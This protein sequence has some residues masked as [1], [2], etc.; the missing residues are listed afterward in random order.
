MFGTANALSRQMTNKSILGR[1]VD[2]LW[3]SKAQKTNLNWQKKF[4]QTDLCIGMGSCQNMWKHFQRKTRLI[5]G[6][7][8]LKVSSPL[9]F[10]TSRRSYQR[11]CFPLICRCGIY[12]RNN[13]KRLYQNILKI[14]VH[15]RRLLWTTS[16]IPVF[17]RLIFV[18]LVWNFYFAV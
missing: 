17:F 5:S 7:T 11:I 3:H 2:P 9:C 4:H 15:H 18:L 12:C 10:N 6:L 14:P 8:P 1:Q 16:A 13:R